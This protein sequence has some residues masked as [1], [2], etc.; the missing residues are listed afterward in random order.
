M[1]AVAQLVEQWFVV[2]LVAGSKP[3]GRPIILIINSLNSIELFFSWKI[4]QLEKI[5]DIM[6]MVTFIL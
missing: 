1:A 2:P 6:V 5:L 3:V 4:L